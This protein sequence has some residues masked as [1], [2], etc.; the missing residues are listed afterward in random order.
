MDADVTYGLVDV[1]PQQPMGMLISDLDQDFWWS[2]CGASADSNDDPAVEPDLGFA[3][4]T[5]RLDSPRFEAPE[6]LASPSK[7]DQ[8]ATIDTADDRKN[9]VWSTDPACGADYTLYDED[10]V[11]VGTLYRDRVWPPSKPNAVVVVMP[12]STLLHPGYLYES[13]GVEAQQVVEE[14]RAVDFLLTGSQEDNHGDNN[15][16]YVEILLDNF[17]I[18]SNGSQRKDDWEMKPLHHLH[19]EAGVSSLA[20]EGVLKSGDRECYV[21]GVP[22]ERVSIGNFGSDHHSVDGN[23]WIETLSNH[24]MG[25]E[26][27]YR[28]GKPSKHYIRFHTVFTWVADLAKHFTDYLADCGKRSRRVSIVDFRGD[29]SRWLQAHHGHDA[30]FQT[31]YAA[32]GK[33]DFCVPAAANIEFLFSQ[34][35]NILGEKEVWHHSIFAETQSFSRF[36]TYESASLQDSTDNESPNRSRKRQQPEIPLTVVTPYIADLFSHPGIACRFMFEPLKLAPNAEELRNKSFNAAHMKLYHQPPD[37]RTARPLASSQLL[38]IAVWNIQ[39]GDTIST[40]RD[41][42]S[43][44][45]WAHAKAHGCDEDDRWFGLVQNA[46]FDALGRRSFG[47]IWYYRPVDTICGE[48][49]YPINNELFLSDNCTCGGARID[50]DEVLGVHEVAFYPHLTSPTADFIV[51]QTYYADD[52]KWVSYRPSHRICPCRREETNFSNFLR[53]YR[54]GDAV[55]ARVKRNRL[56]VCEISSIDADKREVRLRHLLRRNELDPKAG[57]APNEVVYSNDFADYA[58]SRVESKCLVRFFGEGEAIPV[59]YNRDG[60][61]N[62]W[63]LSHEI[64]DGMACRRM[65]EAPAS[66]TQSFLPT[67][68]PDQRILKGLDLFCGGGSFGR[69]LEEGGAIEMRWANDINPK[70]MHTYM[71]NAPNPNR[72][73]PFCGS[74]D[75]LQRLAIEGRFS[76]AVPQIGQVDFICG[77]SPCP[78]FSLVTMDKTTPA[79]RKNQSLVA[80]FASMIDVYRPAFGI[81]ENV[82]SIV[83]S[84]RKKGEDHFCQLICAIV[85]MGYQAR[86]ILGDAWS[87]GACQTRSRVFLVFAAPGEKLPEIPFPT[88]SHPSNVG[89]RG[90]GRL[91]NGGYMARREF[92]EAYAFEHAK[93]QETMADLPDLWDTKAGCISFPDHVHALAVRPQLRAQLKAIPHFPRGLGFVKA[94]ANGKGP[95]LKADRELFPEP[96][97]LRVQ[98][99]SKGWTRIPPD[100]L[101]RTVTTSLHPTDLKT[102][103][104]IHWDLDRPFTVMECRRAQGF[105]DHE[106]LL[107]SSL[108]RLRVVGNSVARQVALALGLSFKGAV[109]GLWESDNQQPVK[110]EAVAEEA[111][112]RR[113]GFQGTKRVA[114]GGPSTQ[115]SK[116][117]CSIRDGSREVIVLD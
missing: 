105:P 101:L 113:E 55:L 95:M 106:V 89:S 34:A 19:T 27:Y 83:Q 33:S 65:A 66:L 39:I 49:K 35:H 18:Y 74:I 45:K 78:G 47:V 6:G 103:A 7:A 96:C 13:E 62:A 71:A 115:V 30:G 112:S 46:E 29:F 116:R 14:G 60:I 11:S 2:N 102:G 97:S 42:A 24:S 52:A 58:Y 57:A 117:Q 8:K 43:I 67:S 100:G 64:T 98:A 51:R 53:D 61:G 84:H 86:M 1:D 17:S 72:V 92:H 26:I 15:G 4:S 85:G 10:G 54:K 28:L 32:Y 22:F 93:A 99:G 69:G 23:I 91:P 114:V 109:S 25:N 88:H 50:E 63:I 16:G 48:M 59:P 38:N 31:W 80:S 12:E 41:D 5:L 68:G 77:G 3:S 37:L 107:G 90:V 56:D 36:P 111:I 73:N 82:V 81:L 87:F 70:A 104:S 108:D 79:Q 76:D 110:A 75:D 44:S 21:R 9:G 20:C 94:W 40:M